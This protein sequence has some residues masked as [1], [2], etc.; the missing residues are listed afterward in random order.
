MLVPTS[1]ARRQTFLGLC[2]TTY[3]IRQLRPHSPP[4]NVPEDSCPVHTQRQFLNAGTHSKR[5]L[6][7]GTHSKRL[8]DVTIL[9][10]QLQ[11]YQFREENSPDTTESGFL[12]S[13]L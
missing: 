7:A 11:S 12:I 6:D 8:L 1:K 4:Q 10:L 13:L 2:D 9:L 3:K 5:L